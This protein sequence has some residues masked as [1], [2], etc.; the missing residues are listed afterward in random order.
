MRPR[1]LGRADNLE[2]LSTLPIH[3]VL[4][5]LAPGFGPLMGI[6]TALM[7]TDK[8]LNLIV[9][10]DM[11]WISEAIVQ[12]LMGAVGPEVEVAASVHPNEG[13]QPFPLLAHAQATHTIGSLLDRGERSLQALLRTKRAATVVI[14]NPVL[15]RAYRNINTMNDYYQLTPETSVAY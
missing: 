12:R 9:P 13:V 1:L 4:T 10:C 2:R 14:D 15:W 7:Q 8:K 5:D 11:P 3:G 6:Y